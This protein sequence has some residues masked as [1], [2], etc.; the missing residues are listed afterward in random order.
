MSLS[1]ILDSKYASLWT[2]PA[3]TQVEIWIIIFLRKWYFIATSKMFSHS[4]SLW[5]RLRNFWITL[6]H[7]VVVW[8]AD[9]LSG[10]I[11]QCF[12]QGR[13]WHKVILLKGLWRERRSH[14]RFGCYWS[15][16]DIGLLGSIRTMPVIVRSPGTKPGD[17][18]GHRFTWP[19]GLVQCLSFLPHG[20]NAWCLG[21]TPN[22]RSEHWKWQAKLLSVWE[23]YLIKDDGQRFG[24]AF[25]FAFS[26]SRIRCCKVE[27]R[28]LINCL[29]FLMLLPEYMK[30][31]SS[32]D[33]VESV[34]TIKT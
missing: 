6:V 13:V 26:C 25:L 33:I 18:A 29:K 10:G 31:W 4:F 5:V 3:K 22:F 12:P 20:T 30:F 16:L 14:T 21:K 23:V 15:M 17:F 2:S 27:G 32:L 19:G 11:Y 1:Q 7:M 34:H 8:G 9:F 28:Q 24:V